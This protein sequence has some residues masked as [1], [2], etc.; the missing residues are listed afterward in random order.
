MINGNNKDMKKYLNDE[1]F[2]RYD[3]LPDDLWNKLNHQISRLADTSCW[4]NVVEEVFSITYQYRNHHD[5]F[6]FWSLNDVLI[7]TCVYTENF[8]YLLD[9][10]LTYS[11]DGIILF[12]KA[13][14]GLVP[15]HIDIDENGK[16]ALTDFGKEHL[17]EINEIFDDNFKKEKAKTGSIKVLEKVLSQNERFRKD[18]DGYR[19]GYFNLFSDFPINIQASLDYCE[20]FNYPIFGT[21]KYDRKKTIHKTNEVQDYFKIL[22]KQ[23]ENDLRDKNGLPRIG[24]GWISETELFYKLLYYFPQ[25]TVT[26]HF[27]AKWLGKQ[28]LDIYIEE[29]KVGVEYH[30]KQHFEPVEFFG[31]QEAIE[32]NRKRDIAKK[33]KCT[34]NGVRLIVVT[35]G[36]SFDELTNE[37]GEYDAEN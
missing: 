1:V 32:K 11:G 3:D 18:N 13:K 33:A 20:R 5:E 22:Y 24:E 25:Y 34:K 9:P 15:N 10:S 4:D 35:E 37:I 30:G 2:V 19:S 21:F 8:E 29:L 7:D 31:G 12:L 6:F 17:D 36:Y 23:A 16:S 26:Q 28:H 27:T 14:A